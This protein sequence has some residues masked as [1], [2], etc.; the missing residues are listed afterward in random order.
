MKAAF[1]FALLWAS[2]LAAGAQPGALSKL[3]RATLFGREFVSLDDWARANRCQVK[4][5]TP[6]REL[7]LSGPG[8]NLL[9]SADSRK[10]TLNGIHLWLS[11][12]IVVRDDSAHITPADLASTI[13]P[14]LWP[15][16]NPVGRKI[17]TIV[18]DPGH[19][20][21]DP[22][23]QEG[24]QQE[25]KYTL[26]LARE[27]GEQLTKAGFKVSLTRATDAKLEL[28]QRP[29]MAQRRGA[30]LFL[31]LHF[32]SADGPGAAAVRGAEVY[33]LTP[34]RASSTND[35]T[36]HGGHATFYPGNRFDARNMALAYQIQRAL[37]RRGGAED[38]GVRRA[39]FEILREAEMPAVL[40]EAAFMTN[41][42]DA[43]RIYDATSRRALAQAI[44]EGVLAYKNLVEP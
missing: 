14:V 20:G 26:L 40:I 3:E 28:A 34:V 18:L 37:V 30:D 2:V 27:L 25:K 29:E 42:S 7:Q 19:G 35:R 16:K 41:S 12:P 17:K 15:S 43:K 39:R 4:W 24:R 31:S 38:R 6:R 22:G 44:T 9:V 8:C 5:I 33:C 32:N 23:N 36:S 10:V 11:T 21:S 1:C 13:H